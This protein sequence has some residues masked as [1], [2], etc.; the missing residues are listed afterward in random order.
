MSDK[1]IINAVYSST[2]DEGVTGFYAKV[3]QDGVTRIERRLENLG[4]YGITWFDVF[5]GEHMFA[6]FNARAV[7][8]VYYERLAS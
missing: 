7:A 6:S 8:D 4:D 2:N 5:K 3:G 1:Q